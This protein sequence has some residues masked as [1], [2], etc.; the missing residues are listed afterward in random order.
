MSTH[1]LHHHIVTGSLTLPLSVVLTLVAWLLPGTGDSLLWGGAAVTLLTAYMVMELNNRFSLIRIRSR[2]M[3]S[4]FLWLMLAC[5]MLHL[6]SADAVSVVCLAG[7][8]FMLFSSYQQIRPEGHVFYAFL[9]TGIGSLFFPPMLV[10]AAGHYTSMIFLLR[11]MNGRSFAAG[12]LGLALPYGAVAGYAIW[13][14]RLD[15]AFDHLQGWLSLSVQDYAQITLWQLVMAAFVAV[16]ALLGVIHLL[17]TAYNDKIRTRM[18]LYVI[19]AQ[20]LLLLV[21]LCLLPAHFE[22]MMRLFILNSTPL[23]AHYFALA[24]GRFFKT[25]FYVS[26]LALTALAVFNYLCLYGPLHEL[27]QLRPLAGLLP[28]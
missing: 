26:L 16:Y 21:L 2:L 28:L 10:L 13:Q 27:S 6:W 3:S 17:R 4:L 8:Y 22:A 14:N 1:T 19:T 18:L 5:P 25:W 12:L 7:C 24:R 20:E 11:C 23:I 9:L 15:T